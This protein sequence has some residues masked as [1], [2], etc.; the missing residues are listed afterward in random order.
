MIPVDS[1]LDLHNLLS[2]GRITLPSEEELM[3]A[4]M[5]LRNARKMQAKKRQRAMDNNTTGAE[6]EPLSQQPPRVALE[7]HELLLDHQSAGEAV[8]PTKTNG[9]ASSRYDD[10]AFNPKEYVLLGK[11]FNGTLSEKDGKDN[12]KKVLKKDI[13]A[14]VTLFDGIEKEKTAALSTVPVPEPAVIKTT[15][16]TV[17][18]VSTATANNSDLTAVAAA[19]FPVQS[20]DRKKD[21]STSEKKSKK[22]K[23]KKDKKHKRDK[24]SRDQEGNHES[25]E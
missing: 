17:P 10:K 21:R 23:K 1:I 18:L 19:G 4:K 22:K 15:P 5:E 13:E 7:C 8:V 16:Q 6:T 24:A 11:A 14:A 25:S 2:S 9:G 3:A 20:N 12:A